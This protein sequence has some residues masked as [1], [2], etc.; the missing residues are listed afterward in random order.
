MENKGECFFVSIEGINLT[1]I[2]V[3]ISV[4][5]IGFT[6]NFGS[7]VVVQLAAAKAT[8][9]SSPSDFKPQADAGQTQTVNSGE[10]VKLDGS[11]SE[12]NCP[13]D[14][15]TYCRTTYDWTQDSG[16][17]QVHLRRSENNPQ[18]TFRAP[19]VNEETVLTFRLVVTNSFMWGGD[20]AV[21]HS[22]PAT[23]DVT[24]EPLSNNR[25]NSGGA[26]G[27]VTQPDNTTYNPWIQ[28]IIG[29]IAIIA[30]IAGGA[31]ALYKHRTRIRDKNLTLQ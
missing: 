29:S 19:D 4:I 8:T 3:V 10:K 28:S 6:P 15:V 5:L 21:E 17:P 25:G 22:E 9:T 1:T 20:N 11:N 31:A 24:V 23:V 30:I 14:E 13:A 27:S 18:A 2:L 12:S 7:F 26:D 16:N